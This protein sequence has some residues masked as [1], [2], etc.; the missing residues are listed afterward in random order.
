VIDVSAGSLGLALPDARYNITQDV[1][2]GS[3][4]NRL[5]HSSTSERRIDIT[6]S[7]GEVTLRPTR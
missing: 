5:D 3:L 4:N 6:L 2:A 1:S 7:A